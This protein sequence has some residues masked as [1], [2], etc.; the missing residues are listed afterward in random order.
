MK[1][2]KKQK[3]G[4]WFSAVVFLCFALI[5]GFAKFNKFKLNSLNDSIQNSGSQINSTEVNEIQNENMTVHFLNVGKADCCYI[6]CKDKNILIDAADKEPTDV[7]TEYLERQKVDKLDLVVV[8]HPHRDHIGQ[9]SKV[10]EK[11]Q[12]DKFIAAKV[13]NDIVPTSTTYEKMLK[14]LEKKNMKIKYVVSGDNFEIGDLKIE[15]LG[16]VNDHSN[17]NSNS[18]VMKIKYGDVSF[19]FTGDAEINEEKDIIKSNADLQSTVLK[20]GHH[21]SKTSSSYNFLRKIKPEYAVISVGPDKSNL[22]KKIILERLGKFCEKIYRTDEKGTIIFK[23]DG[24]SIKV[25]TEK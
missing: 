17:L 14:A 8:S 12:I 7:V 10:I 18:V 2:F 13:P 21:G 15:I 1:P 20:V 4:Y 22:P 24:K 11:F 3:F 19:M 25:E 6:K 5:L 16:P 9:M 23:T